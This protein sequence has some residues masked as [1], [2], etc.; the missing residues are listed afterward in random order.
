MPPTSRP[1]PASGSIASSPFESVQARELRF[2][3][4]LPNRMSAINVCAVGRPFVPPSATLKTK[5]T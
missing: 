3:I 2:N 1:T 4:Y 5:D